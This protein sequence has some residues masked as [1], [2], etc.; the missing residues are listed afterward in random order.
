M[1][2]KKMK[3]TKMGRNAEKFSFAHTPHQHL[4]KSVGEVPAIYPIAIRTSSVRVVHHGGSVRHSPRPH[5]WGGPLSW[6]ERKR[7]PPVCTVRRG[8]HE[9]VRRGVPPGWGRGLVTS[10]RGCRKEMRVNQ[11][12]LSRT[13]LEK[14]LEGAA[15]HHVQAKTK[16]VAIWQMLKIKKRR[17]TKTLQ[18]K[19]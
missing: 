16:P 6:R 5:R 7:Q 1:R 13:Q 15:W 3:S 17:L 9:A 8:E 11:Q 19:L 18:Q 14:K 4:Y 2:W 12:E 10:P